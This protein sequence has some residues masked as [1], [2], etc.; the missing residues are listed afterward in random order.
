[1]VV[2]SAG[3]VTDETGV[4]ELDVGKVE[5]VWRVGVGLV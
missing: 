1:M 3:Q 4:V 2:A 5:W